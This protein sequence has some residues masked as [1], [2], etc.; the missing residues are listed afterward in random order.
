MKKW[1]IW[2]C[3]IIAII[4]SFSFYFW[5]T[6]PDGYYWFNRCKYYNIEFISPFPLWLG[7]IWKNLTGSNYYLFS[8]LGWFIT[9]LSL[10]FPFFYL[11]KKKEWYEN[12]PYLILGIILYGRCS[13]N[14]YAADIPHVFFAVCIVAVMMKS[15]FRNNSS[16]LIFGLL[17]AFFTSC[18]F[19]NILI[20]L[21][22]LFY[23]AISSFLENNSKG[24]LLKKLIIYFCSFSLFY[25]LIIFALTGHM[26]ILS[27]AINEISNITYYYDRT[28]TL[29]SLLKIFYN[30]C[31]DGLLS[32]TV[33]VGSFTIMLFFENLYPK[34]RKILRMF[35][36]IIIFLM[37]IYAYHGNPWLTVY[38]F[39][40]ALLVLYK[41]LRYNTLDYYLKALVVIG[42]AVIC[43]GGS[44]SGLSKMYYFMA[45]IA[46]IVFISYKNDISKKSLYRWFIGIIVAASIYNSNY[47][48]KDYRVWSDIKDVPVL[49]KRNEYKVRKQFLK[50]Y[51]QLNI[52]GQAIFYGF[53]HSHFM[54]AAT[55]T[56]LPY[57]PSYFVGVEKKATQENFEREIDEILNVFNTDKDAVIF[58]LYPTKP[59]EL[60]DRKAKSKGLISKNLSEYTTIYFYENVK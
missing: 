51:Y 47:V 8:L 44:A 18:R 12:L 5:P 23:L 20:V 52:K 9:L 35:I 34:C 2:T 13:Y 39:L 42:I 49:M 19:P 40:I 60:L 14:I 55:R 6:C 50:D 54:Y 58:V 46:P 4:Y 16:I 38:S 17:S 36:S 7:Y 28:H 48:G 15:N 29:A 1:V 31:M 11:I 37:L 21:L 27:F 26:N 25:Y 3:L 33:I 43:C 41:S 24:L 32:I 10:F 56:E 53:P 22:G 30:S 45:A 59:S 57:K